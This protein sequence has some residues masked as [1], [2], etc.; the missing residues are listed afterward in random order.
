[1]K[2][3]IILGALLCFALTA[4]RDPKKQE[5]SSTKGNNA[6]TVIQINTSYG[7]E[8]P[9]DSAG[10]SHAHTSYIDEDE[11][12]ADEPPIVDED[13]ANIGIN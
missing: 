2:K 8:E 5:E 7:T 6:E 11:G 3:K 9:S 10:S 12:A 1:M 13:D 4:C